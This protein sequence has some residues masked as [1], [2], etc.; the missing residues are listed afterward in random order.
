MFQLL[1]CLRCE[2]VEQSVYQN[3]YTAT[4]LAGSGMRSGYDDQ[5]GPDLNTP[6]HAN[7]HTNRQV[8]AR[9]S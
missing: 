6:T 5:P 4:F 2:A 1:G 8:Y 3:K 7:T 9:L